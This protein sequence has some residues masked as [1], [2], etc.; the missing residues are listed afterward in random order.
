[1]L[2]DRHRDSR[3]STDT[4]RRHR[5]THIARI[6]A[7]TRRAPSRGRRPATASW[8]ADAAVDRN[9][10]VTA[11]VDALTADAT[12]RL[13]L[14]WEIG[15][16]WQLACADVDRALDGVRW[17]VDEI[18]PACVDR[19]SSRRCPARSATSRRWNYPMS[20]LVHAELVQLLAGN[21]VIAKTPTQGGAVLPD[22]RARADATT[23][24]CR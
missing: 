14:A 20:V 12:C 17:Y 18:E 19:P 16:P 1:M 2:V 21:A 22:R 24:A 7:D 6:D 8:A 13:L 23:P 15:K 3:A 4:G 5:L 10:R 11:A 9:A